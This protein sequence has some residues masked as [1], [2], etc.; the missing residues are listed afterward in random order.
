MSTPYVLPSAPV[1][2]SPRTIPLVITAIVHVVVIVAFASGLRLSD[3]TEPVPVMTA[4][5]VPDTAPSQPKPEIIEPV[6]KTL[7]ASQLD[8]PAPPIISIEPDVAVSVTTETSIT[9]EPQSQNTGAPSFADLRLVHKTDP[10]YPPASRRFDEEGMVLVKLTVAANGRVID[11][12]V[13]TSSG[14]PRLDQA[15]LEAV[16]TWRFASAGG[17]DRAIVSV[18]VKFELNRR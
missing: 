11:A 8:I 4:F 9:T 17:S 2:S 18:P 12:A 6:D 15:A 5:Q 10:L 1:G 14:Y 13:Q 16:R 3:F 7:A